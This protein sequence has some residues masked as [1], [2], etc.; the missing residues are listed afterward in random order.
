MR[1]VVVAVKRLFELLTVVAPW[2]ET[3]MRY[4]FAT[5]LCSILSTSASAARPNIVIILCDDLGYG[6]IGVH[7]HP[8]IQSPNID[9]LAN[10][11][12]RFTNFYSTAPVCS[13]SRVGLLTGRSPNRAG[14][15]DWIP[16]SKQPRPDARE[17]VHM[18]KSEI[19]IAELLKKAG[20]ATCMAGKWH[21]NATFNSP[22]QAQPNDAGFD[23]WMATQNNASPSHADPVNYV[24][25]GVPV[26]KIEGYSCQIAADEVVSWMGTHV[27]DNSEQPFFIYLPFH[28]PHEP[29]ASPPELVDQYKD[30]TWHPDQAQYY[31][32]VH[33][34]DLAVGKV[35]RALQKLGVRDNTLIAFTSDNGPETLNRYRSA[36]RSWGITAHLRGM[37][38]HTHDGGFHVVGIVNWPNGI[39]PG[40]VV[41][42]PASALDLLPTACSLAEAVIPAD[43][44]LDGMSLSSFFATGQTVARKKPL[45]WAYYN[46]IND[47]RVAMRHGE[48]KVLARLNG[49]R[50][51]KR[52][53]LTPT[54][55][56]EAKSAKLTDFEIYNIAADPGE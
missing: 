6:D 49:G 26:G 2:N 21:C 20:Y 13:P 39:K 46:G 31:A 44:S 19:T 50:F 54:T 5:L 28:E 35:V 56:A 16:E 1:P 43:R 22:E 14:V 25:N 53:N 45:V 17:Q 30:V 18:R 47:A 12:I 32:N 8:H 37:K 36:N 42:T 4:F 7:G 48:W 15:Y 27:K 24:R 34:V 52:Q 3:T 51:S 29:V 55:L 9:R 38:L 40:Q 23:H 33:N 41:D 10:E 11:G